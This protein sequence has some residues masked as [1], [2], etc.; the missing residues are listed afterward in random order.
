[1]TSSL[2]SH[3]GSVAAVYRRAP[4]SL[5]S[6]RLVFFRREHDATGVLKDFTFY[7]EF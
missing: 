7:D 6:G 2:P 5:R 4:E 3:A 1:M